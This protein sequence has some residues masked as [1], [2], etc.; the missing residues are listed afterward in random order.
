MFRTGR[1]LANRSSALRRPT[2]TLVKPP[3]I[4]VVT[5]PFSATLLRSI[6]SSSS[7]QRGAVSLERQHAGQVR[8]QSIERRVED[9]DDSRHFGADPVAGDEGDGMFQVVR[10]DRARLRAASC[11]PAEAARLS[12]SMSISPSTRSPRMIGTTISD[13]VS[14]LQA[15]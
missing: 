14:M 12:L 7:R 4:G 1:R 6:E 9:R 13:S 10:K 3:P 8:S 15:R 5:G 2:L 11:L